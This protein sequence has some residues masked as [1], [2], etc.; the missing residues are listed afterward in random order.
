[1]ASTASLPMPAEAENK[2]ETME[3]LKGK[4][5]GKQRQKYA[6]GAEYPKY[7]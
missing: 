6:P 3:G 4:D 2:Y 1:M 7:M 5:Y